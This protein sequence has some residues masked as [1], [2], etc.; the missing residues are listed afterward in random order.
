MHRLASALAVA[1]RVALATP[2]SAQLTLKGGV[3]LVDVFGDDVESSDRR[4]R[5]AAGAS[6]DVLSLGPVTLSPEIFYAQKGAESFRSGLQQGS[7]ARVSLEYVE[8]PVLLKVALP[9]GERFSPYLAG[10]PVFGWQLDC[11]VEV[12]QGGADEACD[13]L[14][15]GEAQLEETLRSYEQGLAFGA[16]VAFDL[17]GGVGG[18]TLDARY[19]LGLSRLSEDDDGPDIQNRAFAL[20]LGYRLG[21]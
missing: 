13:E 21:G 8:V 3:N 6:F 16:G 1:L 5:L 7:P 15:G 9:F 4:A 18:V 11:S 10:G 14:L 19:S 2:L 20:L 17:P 12:D